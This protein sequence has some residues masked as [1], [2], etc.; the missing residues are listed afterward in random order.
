MEGDNSTTHTAQ[1][2]KDHQEGNLKQINHLT[3]LLKK[4]LKMHGIQIKDIIEALQL[5]IDDQTD[6]HD[7]KVKVTDTTNDNTWREPQTASSA[8]SSTP[9][10]ESVHNQSQTSVPSM[11]ASYESIAID[12]NDTHAEPPTHSQ[13]QTPTNELEIDDL[14]SRLYKHKFDTNNVNNGSYHDKRPN[15]NR[16]TDNEYRAVINKG[17]HTGVL[18]R[19]TLPTPNFDTTDQA[20]I[21]STMD[22]I[23]AKTSNDTRET[24]PDT[25]PNNKQNKYVSGYVYDASPSETSQD[26]ESEDTALTRTAE[27]A[28]ITAT[29]GTS[30]PKPRNYT[31][32]DIENLIADKPIGDASEDTLFD[33]RPDTPSDISQCQPLPPLR[34]LL[35]LNKSPSAN[36]DKKGVNS[37]HDSDTDHQ[38]LG[39]KRKPKGHHTTARQ[40]NNIQEPN[41]TNR[42]HVSLNDQELH[43]QG[44]WKPHF[45]NF[46]TRMKNEGEYKT[47]DGT[48]Y[49]LSDDAFE[50]VMMHT[51]MPPHP[52]QRTHTPNSST[53]QGTRSSSFDTYQ[54]RKIDQEEI[55]VPTKYTGNTE[56]RT[57]KKGIIKRVT[58][59]LFKSKKQTDED[60]TNKATLATITAQ[61]DDV[62]FDINDSTDFNDNNSEYETDSDTNTDITMY[63]TQ[64]DGHHDLRDHDELA[65]QEPNLQDHWEHH[66]HV[67]ERVTTTET[68]NDLYDDLHETYIESAINTMDKMSSL[69]DL[70]QL[71]ND[72]ND[73]TQMEQGHTLHKLQAHFNVTNLVNPMEQTYMND[74][75][76]LQ[77]RLFAMTSAQI[78]SLKQKTHPT[79][80]TKFNSAAEN[81]ITIQNQLLNFSIAISTIPDKTRRNRQVQDK[82]NDVAL[83][84]QQLKK[85]ESKLEGLLT[86]LSTSAYNNHNIPLPAKFGTITKL[87]INDFTNMTKFLPNGKNKISHVW[88]SMYERGKLIGK[89]SKTD[90]EGD[91]LSEDAWKDALSQHL[92]GEALDIH[93]HYNH[94]PLAQLLEKLHNR[95]ERIPSRGELHREIDSFKKDAQDSLSCTV[96][97]LRLTLSKLYHDKQPEEREI[98]IRRTIREKIINNNWLPSDIIRNILRE[99]D[100]ARTTCQPF[101]FETRAKDM[102]YWSKQT[103]GDL[104]H[105]NEVLVGG[106]HAMATKRPEIDPLKRTQGGRVDNHQH[107]KPSSRPNTPTT[108]QLP[109]GGLR[110]GRTGQPGY[111]IN[112]PGGKHPR[113]STR[114]GQQQQTNNRRDQSRSDR[115]NN[116]NSKPRPDTQHNPKPMEQDG[117]SENMRNIYNN[118]RNTYAHTYQ[119]TNDNNSTSRNWTT[120][121]DLCFYHSQYGDRAIKCTPP[122]NFVPRDNSYSYRQGQAYRYNNDQYQPS[123]GQNSKTHYP[124]TP[125]RD[126]VFRSETEFSSDPQ[127]VISSKFTIDEACRRYQCRDRTIHAYN[128]C[129]F[130]QKKP[131]FQQRR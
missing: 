102:D 86:T 85:E 32:K 44:T 130:I 34:S 33:S 16:H 96:E 29:K 119:P 5:P 42:V 82:I 101:C 24:R 2:H 36:K 99:E 46:I 57:T 93:Y 91:C 106:L 52:H 113:Y 116:Y 11:I 39:A 71:E 38:L 70:L 126:K 20:I 65:T 112:N 115:H 31:L 72:D 67:M 98:L 97:K 129:P 6:K 43:L 13:R 50:D 74:D 121:P 100:D 60:E 12:T 51:Q 27:H 19:P 62:F 8:I 35:H 58:D 87:R 105:N 108:T 15:E 47:F 7:S 40:V 4:D 103:D 21:Q 90:E 68:G 26:D 73:T 49:F 18:K 22:M 114:T 120:N 92:L 17:I 123:G 111:T 128:N 81:L 14:T 89:R 54:H 78:S 10:V 56:E 84:V 77:T 124:K 83:A 61:D 76:P 75:E 109:T 104:Y 41:A 53:S 9:T 131:D 125:G 1:V 88:K 48:T 64:T 30:S 117:P 3:E 59:T 25:I 110:H 23:L 66:K 122:C 37:K 107:S 95:F 69:T 118:D 94:L 55:L 127:L 28:V 45:R 63:R 79:R 80:L